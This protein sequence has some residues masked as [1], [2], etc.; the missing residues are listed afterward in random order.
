VLLVIFELLE[1]KTET[2]A[3]LSELNSRVVLHKYVLGE[4]EYI[5]IFSCNELD[6]NPVRLIEW[7][8]YF[9]YFFILVAEWEEE[10]KGNYI[11]EN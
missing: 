3:Q 6:R 7:K 2:L 10:Q 5:F 1:E 8:E 11:Y 4:Y 9:G